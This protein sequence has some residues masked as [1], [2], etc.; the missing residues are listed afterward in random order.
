MSVQLY[1]MRR[2]V[3]ILLRSF[4]VRIKCLG[5]YIE[6]FL[7]N[8]F[9]FHWL[10]FYFRTF[11]KKIEV[12]NLNRRNKLFN[13]WWSALC[14]LIAMQEKRRKMLLFGMVSVPRYDLLDSDG[15]INVLCWFSEKRRTSYDSPC[16]QTGMPWYR[17]KVLV[18][19]STAAERGWLTSFLTRGHCFCFFCGQNSAFF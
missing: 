8:I 1:F 18:V 16:K 6:T 10:C 19:D 5:V 3:F 12:I 9:H 17:G 4:R 2:E 7:L 14:Y 15:T 13:I 11:V